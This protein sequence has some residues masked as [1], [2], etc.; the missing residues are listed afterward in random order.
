MTGNHRIYIENLDALKVFAQALANVLDAGDI[1]ALRGT[2]GAGKTTFSQHLCQAL[3]VTE[4]VTSPTFTLLNEYE[5]GEKKVL[6]GDLYRLSAPEMDPFLDQV[7]S[8]LACP[9]CLLLMEWADLSPSFWAGA[10]WQV[11]LEADSQ[12]PDARW[13]TVESPD[14]ERLQ[15]ILKSGGSRC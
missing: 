14:L 11:T 5:A 2:L 1:V 7:E 9:R 6:H 10:S 3:G 13:A 12:N 15:A 4:P 8:S